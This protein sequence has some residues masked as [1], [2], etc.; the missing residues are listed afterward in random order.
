MENTSLTSA[1][2]VG[3][4]EKLADRA[5]EAL[6][7]YLGN[8]NEEN[9][10]NVRASVRRMNTCI[11][12]LPKK[13][14]SK[15]VRQRRDRSRKLLALTSEVRDNDMIR[16]RL[17]GRAGDPTVD[18]LLKN[19]GEERE[20]HAV[21]SMKAAWKLFELRGPKLTKKEAARVSQWVKRALEELDE[22]IGAELTIVVKSEGRIDELHSLRKHAK[23]FRYA[24]ELIPPTRRSSKVVQ[25][26]KEWQDVLGKIRDS[27]V[28][29][30]YLG[31][32]RPSTVIKEMLLT[33]R[34]LRH[35]RY[36]AF[37][38]ASRRGSHEKNA[39]LLASTGLK[40]ATSKSGS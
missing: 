35:R 1:R 37:V 36:L 7:K 29:I 24:L 14:R 12:I 22:E 11:G 30:E 20:K 27:D 4:Y 31:R 21:D 39:F 10:R 38:R 15:T 28:V 13:A 25:G 8:P 33:E 17:S 6:R 18:L 9:T 19:M 34:S 26:L 2:F 40:Q 3:E 16:A 32:A 23:R 5:G